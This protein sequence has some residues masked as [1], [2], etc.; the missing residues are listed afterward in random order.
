MKQYLII[1]IFL[2]TTLSIQAQQQDS[3]KSPIT[4]KKL[5]VGLSNIP[6]MLV[7]DGR[8]ISGSIESLVTPYIGYKL[9][10]RFNI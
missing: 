7:Q 4:D 3:V 8:G 9:S 1:L 6:Y 10:R 2:L 5:Y